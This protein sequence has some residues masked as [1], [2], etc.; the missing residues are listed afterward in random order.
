M[1]QI[2]RQVKSARRRLVVQQFLA[3]A[4]WWLFGSLVVAT[5]ALAVPKI[6]PVGVDPNQW[7]IW[8]LAG[9]LAAGI[10]LSLIWTFVVRRGSLDAAIELDRR[11]GLKE[12]VSSALC[13]SADERDTEAGQAL[14]DDATRRVEQVS[15]SDEF[16]VQASRRIL[17]PLIPAVVIFCLLMF[18]PDAQQEEA[19][20]ATDVA[21]LRER[22]KKQSELLKKQ[23]KKREKGVE[24]KVPEAEALFNKL[25]KGLDDLAGDDKVDRQKA[26]IKMNDLAKEVEKRRQSLGDPEKMKQQLSRLNKIDRGPAEKAVR[27]MQEGNFEKALEQ[28]KQLTEKLRDG[29]L[30]E[31]DKKQ[32][33]EQLK[34]MQQQLQDMADAQKQAKEDLK[35][36]IQQKM[37]QGDLDGASQLQRKLDQLER[38]DK[39][40][41][42]MEKMA[43]QLGEAQQ[44]M[45]NGDMQSAA[46]K[47]DQLAEELS[48]MQSEMGEME[49]LDEVM[50]AIAEA[51]EM[52]RQDGNGAGG[53]A[54][55]DMDMDEFGNMEGDGSNQG[56]GAGYRPE[57]ETETG[58]Y[59]ARQR[60]K[61][62]K[63]EAVR[64]G[65]AF[66]PNRS[67]M[68]QAEIKEQILSSLDADAD[69]LTDQKLPR[70]QRDHVRE[71]YQ[72]LGKE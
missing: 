35:R 20:A 37:A 68:S 6:W 41:Q 57:E 19:N 49:S 15:V 51:K 61:P 52:M 50:D 70:S 13:L 11:Y 23:L 18:V 38:Q 72:R 21:A 67:G 58:E 7:A 14:I 43:Q 65:D 2:Q 4:P 46:D 56:R 63:G 29:D 30:S 8:W 54:G 45:Q 34:Q 33:A 62:K 25:Q 39:Q 69:P 12:R 53:L 10:V 44:A 47:L 40:M 48:D 28:M 32:L 42:R 5:I 55:L 24:S 66:G 26:L 59:D 1:E 17:L 36:Q 27:A 31:E 64:I 9:G 22:L 16:G 3:T 71:Y 60:A